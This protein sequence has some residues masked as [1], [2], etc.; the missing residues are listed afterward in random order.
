M[1]FVPR[2]SDILA[3]EVMARSAVA[4]H[5]L[6][7]TKDVR[8][9]H[10][11]IDSRLFRG[12]KNALREL[13]HNKCAYCESSLHASFGDIDQFRPARIYWWL[14]YDWDNMLLSCRVC[15]VAKADRFPIAG[16]LA[17]PPARG[18]ELSAEQ[19][20]LLDPCTDHPEEHLVFKEMGDVVGLTDRGLVTID[21]LQLNRS[22][23]IEARRLA[24]TNALIFS[25]HYFSKVS[26]G[27]TQDIQA[28]ISDLLDPKREYASAVRQAW[29]AF[30]DKRSEAFPGAPQTPL[31]QEI[32]SVTRATSPKEIREADKKTL[33]LKE[34]QRSYSIESPN[35]TH[36]DLYKRSSKR[37]ERIEFHNFR[38]FESL[39]LDMPQVTHNYE[40]WL[41]LIGENGL[42]KTSILQGLAL[43]LMGQ[44]R[45]NAVRIDSRR[46]VGRGA[47]VKSGYVRVTVTGVGDIKLSFHLNSPRFTIVPWEPK[48]PLLG[49]GATRLLPRQLGRGASLA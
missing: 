6:I 9:A 47:G 46:G 40:A 16:E 29:R 20:V 17:K 34:A 33:Q 15:N 23:L 2:R 48:I 22:P 45:A 41:M 44:K 49:Y 12:F 30:T 38:N 13:F 11:R 31:V 3:P 10:A 21:V 19:P 18:A 26:V 28:G 4:S 32:R 27:H 39:Q 5:N 36:K 1:I 35:K 37:I 8:P 43:T 25:E 42:G 24:I 7:R 14:F